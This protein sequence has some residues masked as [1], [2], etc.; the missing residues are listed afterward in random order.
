[1]ASL[2]KVT[3]APHP[4]DFGAV[5]AYM[6]PHV[7]PFVDG[8]AWIHLIDPTLI[9]EDINI[10]AGTMTVTGGPVWSGWARV[11]PIRND[12]NAWRATNPTTTRTVQFWVEFPEDQTIDI[13]PGFRICV[14]P[15]VDGDNNDPWLAEYQYVV[16]GGLNSTQAWQRTI[17]TQ[18]DLEIRPNYDTAAW[19]KPPEA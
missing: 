11:Q 10:K 15:L 4:S 6:K 8:K 9:E 5:A 14:D 19:P 7:E 12:V 3:G 2:P 18:V 1:V 13:K 17:N 16:M